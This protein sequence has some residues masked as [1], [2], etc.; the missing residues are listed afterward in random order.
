MA[1]TGPAL[2]R[3]V[4][5][6]IRLVRRY[7]FTSFG[8]VGATVMGAGYCIVNELQN[9]SPIRAVAAVSTVIGAAMLQT[10]LLT[11]IGYHLI[12]RY[13]RNRAYDGRPGSEK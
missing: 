1:E 8:V 5:E 10:A 12:N 9:D 11:G 3:K 2:E 6:G 4:T 13:N 7:P